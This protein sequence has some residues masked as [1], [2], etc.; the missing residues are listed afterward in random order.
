MIC[1]QVVILLVF[2]VVGFMHLCLWGVSD[3]L[4]EGFFFV[5]EICIK[6]KDFWR[7]HIAI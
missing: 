5:A 2:L 6:Q 1:L 7:T 3:A 4:G